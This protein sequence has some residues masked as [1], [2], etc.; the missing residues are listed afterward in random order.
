MS[1]I[2]LYIL[3]SLDERGEMHGHQLRQL[4]DQEHVSH[5]TDISVGSLYGALKR[6]AAEGLIE[7]VRVEQVGGYPARQVWGITAD[8]RASLS[9]LRAEGLRTVV[10]KPDPF[11]LALARLHPDW[12]GE[13]AAL[14]EERLGDLRA[15]LADFQRVE[16]IAD[17]H[18]TPLERFTITHRAS[19]LHTEIDWHEQL[20]AQLPALLAD[21]AERNTS[22]D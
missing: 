9:A 15:L 11:D 10:I 12:H 19:R 20:L 5:W 17:P 18:L 1:S 4:A 16:R 14:V 13:V 22:H 3:D 21:E 7:E 8:G 2:R 6:L